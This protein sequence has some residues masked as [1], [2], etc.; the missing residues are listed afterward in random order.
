MVAVKIDVVPA[1]GVVVAP[2][3]AV[4]VVDVDVAVEVVNFVGAFLLQLKLLMLLLFQ[5]L[6]LLMLIWLLLLEMLILL[7]L[8]QYYK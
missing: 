2:I 5:L 6:W 4:K 7:S 3:V 1:V 8:Y